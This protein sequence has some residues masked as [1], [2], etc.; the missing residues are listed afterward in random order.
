MLVPLGGPLGPPR[1]PT[2]VLSALFAEGGPLVGGAWVDPNDATVDVVVGGGCVEPCGPIVDVVGGGSVEPCEPTLEVVV[3][4]VVGVGAVVV[5]EP[6]HGPINATEVAPDFVNPSLH[7]TFTLSVTLPVA[8]AGTTVL[9]GVECEEL[10]LGP[11][12]AW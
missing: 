9:A 12:V 3:R 6:M 8:A 1:G 7:R 11:T 4:M 5:V 2:G 10:P